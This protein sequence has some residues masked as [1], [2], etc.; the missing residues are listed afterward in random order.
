MLER[1]TASLAYLQ[2]G[3]EFEQ[4]V[5]VPAS[6]IHPNSEVGF[7]RSLILNSFRRQVSGSFARYGSRS[8]KTR[9]F[10]PLTVV[11][12]LSFELV[13]LPLLTGVQGDVIPTQPDITN[14]TDVYRWR[15]APPLTGEQNIDTLTFEYAQRASSSQRGYVAASFGC[16]DFSIN[17]GTGLQPNITALYMGQ[18]H[19]VATPTAGLIEPEL[20]YANSANYRMFDNADGG[21]YGTTPV[22]G[23]LQSLNARFNGFVAPD[24]KGDTRASKDFHS[25]IF[26]DQRLLEVQGEIAI[27]LGQDDFLNR[28]ESYIY[29]SK[30]QTVRRIRFAIEGS[31]L[32]GGFYNALWID[33]P[34]LHAQDSLQ[35][36]DVDEFGRAI[37]SFHMYSVDDGEQDVAFTVTNKLQN[38][39]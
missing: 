10:T 14:A 6:T 4:G 8:V 34:L 9:H 13:L 31:P 19:K 20:S 18:K 11:N 25:F 23:Q 7:E 30:V 37:I 26:N 17:L 1:A 5:I 2:Y 38:P 36:I 33:A 3:I 35:V 22:R 29:D 15:F 28:H 27:N 12:P 39:L 16:V 32:S 21:V 24:Y